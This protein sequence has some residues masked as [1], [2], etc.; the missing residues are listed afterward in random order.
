MK[1]K[2]SSILGAILMFCTCIVFNS[3]VISAG[4]NTLTGETEKMVI[5]GF[6][7]GPGVTKI[8]ISLDNEITEINKNDLLL[9]ETKQGVFGDVEEPKE[10]EIAAAYISDIEG[11]Q[12]IAGAS[13]KYITI[14]P[15]VH[16]DKGSSPFS[17]LLTSFTNVYSEPYILEVTLREGATIGTYDT[18]D[19]ET[20][21]KRKEKPLT[22]LFETGSYTSEGITHSYASYTPPTDEKKNPL[23]IW[24][25]GAGEGGSDPEMIVLGNRVT[26]LVDDEFQTTLGGAYI[27]APQSPTMWM[28]DGSGAYTQDGNSMYSDSLMNLIEEYVAN[29]PDIDTDRIYIGGCSNG[30]FMVMNLLFKSPTYFAAAFPICEAYEDAWIADEMLETIK[31]IPIWFTTALDD[32]TVVSEDNAIPTVARLKAMGALDVRLSTFDNVIDLSGRYKQDDGTP[33]QYMGHWSW[34]Y[35][36][37][38]ECV[39]ENGQTIFAW[40]A[41]QT[42]TVETPKAKGSAEGGP[43]AGL[44]DNRSLLF[45]LAMLG[46]VGIVVSKKLKE[47]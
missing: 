2:I 4:G 39:D 25:H 47:N 14:K 20:T 16:P 29:N 23:V 42:Q 34:I 30:G 12:S 1:R 40:L 11:N 38:N 3:T 27:L 32:T 6:D 36:L 8:V 28:D 7:W 43:K 21:P 17:F 44:Q 35:T 24:L 13:S 41:K 22:N 18:L 5:E 33:Y 9:K 37:N 26:A 15:V 10:K 31:H 45:A 46:F 19:I